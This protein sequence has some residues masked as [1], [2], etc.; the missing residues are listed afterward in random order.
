[1][2]DEIARAVAD[3]IRRAAASGQAID[4]TVASSLKGAADRNGWTVAATPVEHSGAT[5][6]VIA[7]V[8]TPA[9]GPGDEPSQYGSRRSL[10]ARERQVAKLVAH[11]ATNTEIAKALGISYH[12]ARH[13][14]QRLLDKLGVRSRTAVRRS[15]EY[16]SDPKCA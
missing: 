15:G 12:T 2:A 11:G 6:L 5:A 16:D 9:Q 1:M 4:R 8:I 3:G 7:V 10:T 13:H 14:V